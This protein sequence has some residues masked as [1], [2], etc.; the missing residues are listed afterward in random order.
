MKN[1]LVTGNKI[2]HYGTWMYDVAGI[3]TLSAQ[4]GS[5]IA[6]TKLIAFINRNMPICQSTGFIST[7]MKELLFYN[8]EQLDACTKVFSKCKWPWKYLAK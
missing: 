8:K 2:H 3:Y 5:V 6:T 1:N 4:P 7:P